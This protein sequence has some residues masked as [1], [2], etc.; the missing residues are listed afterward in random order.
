MPS[1]HQ[2]HLLNRHSFGLRQIK[3]H[4]KWHEKVSYIKENKEA[5]LEGT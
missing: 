4:K 2:F 5:P 3:E 1:P